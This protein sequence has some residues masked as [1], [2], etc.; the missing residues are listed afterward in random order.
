MI[1]DPL[2]LHGGDRDFERAR[3]PMMEIP[4]RSKQKGFEGGRPPVSGFRQR[5]KHTGQEK[6]YFGVVIVVV[7]FFLSLSL[8][9]LDDLRD[10]RST[11][12]AHKSWLNLVNIAVERQ[13]RER[14]LCRWRLTREES[15]N[16]R[17][18]KKRF[19]LA[20]F[21]I[22]F[23]YTYLFFLDDTLFELNKYSR[24]CEKKS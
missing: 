13:Q 14:T 22:I 7:R 10:C 18:K 2:R 9:W 1:N 17:E 3:A 16:I 24:N 15:N 23:L 11:G 21:F 6:R 12:R 4:R 5:K 8:R 19:S 20:S